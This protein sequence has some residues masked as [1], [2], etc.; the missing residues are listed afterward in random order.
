MMPKLFNPELVKDSVRQTKLQLDGATGKKKSVKAFFVVFQ[1]QL[2]LQ[3]KYGQEFYRF[4]VVEAN[5]IEKKYNEVHNI[6]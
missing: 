1:G 6:R 5:E 4:N 2:Q 3:V